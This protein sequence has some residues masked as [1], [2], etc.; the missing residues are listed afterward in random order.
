M[1]ILISAVLIVHGFITA[2]QSAGSFGS[3]APSPIQNPSWVSWWPTSLGQSWLLS[4]LGLENVPILWRLAGLL[5]LAGGISLV[6]AGLG[7]SGFIIPADWWRALA[8]AGAIISLG[9]LLLYLHP[10]AIL[11]TGLSIAI[12]VVLIWAQ[13]P[14][15]NLLQ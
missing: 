5:W 4:W 9:M 12:L 7:V 10:L 6:G 3:A 1:Q 11:G 14:T 8:I 2:A 13:W 15:T